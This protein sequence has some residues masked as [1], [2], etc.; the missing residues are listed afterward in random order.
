MVLYDIPHIE[1]FPSVQEFAS[2]ARLAK[3]R[4]ASAGNRSGTSGQTIGNAPLKWAF[5]EAATLLLRTKPQGQ[6]L[7]ARVETKPDQGKAL[8]ILAHKLGRAV[9][10]MLKRQGA[11]EMAHLLRS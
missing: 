7:L 5:A 3:G 2:Y 9:S 4:Q 10:C 8:S 6:K 1:R 11:C